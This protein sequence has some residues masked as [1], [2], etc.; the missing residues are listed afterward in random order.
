M[1]TLMM[2]VAM[3]MLAGVASAADQEISVHYGNPGQSKVSRIG[4]SKWNRLLF[5]PKVEI[6]TIPKGSL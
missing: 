1:R 2:I 3:M 4:G 5:S 6:K